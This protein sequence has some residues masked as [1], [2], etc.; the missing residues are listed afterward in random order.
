MRGVFRWLANAALV[1]AIVAMLAPGAYAA[2]PPSPLDPPE[3]RIQPP[4]G[5]ASEARIRPP[6]GEPA[7]ARVQPPNGGASQS[8]V[9]PPIGA[10][11][12]SLV[13]LLRA[14]IEEQV[15]VILE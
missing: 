15:G 6:T 11:E 10:S 2:D 7:E 1:A 14:W 8:R 3:A 5:V 12:P 9:R 13:D 4:T